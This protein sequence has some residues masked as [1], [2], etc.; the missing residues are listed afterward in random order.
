MGGPLIG[1]DDAHQGLLV[2]DGTW[3]LVAKM[4]ADYTK[5]PVRS[6]PPLQTAYPRRSKTLDDPDNG[7]ASIEAL[8]AAYH[9]MDRTT[10]G[11]LDHYRWANQFLAA[12]SSCLTNHQIPPVPG[13]APLV[14]PADPNRPK[15]PAASGK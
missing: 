7:L 2:L 3:R 15:N 11:L 6:L 14:K 13:P 9:L 12:N 8:F 10:D 1:P 5:L 4:E